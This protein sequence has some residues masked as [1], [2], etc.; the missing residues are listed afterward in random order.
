MVAS[1]SL[2]YTKRKKASNK[3][4]EMRDEK[5]DGSSCSS[6]RSF[7]KRKASSNGAKQIMNRGICIMNH[8]IT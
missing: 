2:P 7:C 6:S 5:S 8:T 4:G 3:Q 1:P